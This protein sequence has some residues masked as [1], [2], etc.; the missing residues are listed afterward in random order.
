MTVRKR[1]AQA[2]SDH[3]GGQPSMLVRAP[4]RV[5]LLGEHTDYNDGYVLP[6]TIDRSVR[7]A[8]RPLANRRVRLF[9]LDMGEMAAFG[10]DSFQREGRTW[11][12]Y[13]KGMA[14]AFQEDGYPL[15]GWEGVMSGDVPIGAGL[16]S[17]AAVEMAVGRAFLAVAG[18]DWDPMIVARLGQ[19]SENRWIGVN[20]GIM[21]QMISA[22]G[23]AGHALWIDC[24]TLE[25]E[26][27]PLPRGA[28]VVILD[29]GLRR[30]LLA[31]AYNERRGQCDAAAAHFGVP[32]LRDVDLHTFRARAGGL[33][34][35]TRL[36]ARHVVTENQRVLQGREALRR[37]D[38]P[39]LGALMTASHASL[40]DEF[41]VSSPELDT[42]AAIAQ[43]SDGCFGARMTGAGFGGCAVALV[44][45]NAVREFI[46]A[47]SRAYQGATRLEPEV[48]VCQATH[49][50][51][52]LPVPGQ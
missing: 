39:A 42:M 14:W 47:V 50:A 28:A 30:G 12:E 18:H 29:T 22:A 17:S 36:R 4:G 1:L 8:L 52:V 26:A 9:S 45:I 40:R 20:S 15:A 49:G 51:E 46:P 2:F 19:L 33:D 13:I 38:A 27:L 35:T 43:R 41:E 25:T 34:E 10:L 11:I 44:R 48:Y 23:Q 21:D 37:G 16:G 24:R 7:I 6:M 3:F 5:N 31:S 32:A